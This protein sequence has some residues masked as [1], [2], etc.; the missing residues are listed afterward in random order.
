MML[1]SSECLEIP[2]AQELIS[3]TIAM[4]CAV[5]MNME[6][7]VEAVVPEV[8]ALVKCDSEV[9]FPCLLYKCLAL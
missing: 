1:P 4:L 8:S 7:S 2:G 3:C 5:G 6:M 9:P